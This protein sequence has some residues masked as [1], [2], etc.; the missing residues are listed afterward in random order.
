M[1]EN[2]LDVDSGGNVGENIKIKSTSFTQDILCTYSK[3]M[4]IYMLLV[5]LRNTSN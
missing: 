2:N 5:T 3:C 4:Y 1:L